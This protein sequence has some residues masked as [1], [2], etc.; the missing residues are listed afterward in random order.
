[1]MENYEMIQVDFDI[2]LLS[3]V[4]KLLGSRLLGWVRSEGHQNS[5]VIQD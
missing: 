1:M 3:D 2:V 5:A 4:I